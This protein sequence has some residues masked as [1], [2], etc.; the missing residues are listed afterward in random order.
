MRS[1][2]RAV[3]WA[4]ALLVGA[5]NP[6]LAQPSPRI[7]VMP[8]ENVA[9]DPQI[10]WLGE[11][12]S[13]LLADNLNALGARAI[14][15]EERQDAFNHLQ[16][17]ST[18]PLS[19]AMTLRIGQLVGASRVVLGTIRRTGDSLVVQAR[20]IALETGRA[21]RPEGEAAP[22]GDLFA[23]FDRLASRLVTAGA[24]AP[25]RTPPSLAAF[26]SY[27]KGLLAE[28]PAT[29]VTYFNAALRAQPSFDRARMAMWDIH[30]SQ[31]EHDRALAS[32]STILQASDLYR[33]ARFRVGLS[34]LQLRRH[35]EAF[36][37]FKLLSDAK[38]SAALANNMGVVQVRRG[39]TPQ[40]GQPTYFFTR[41]VETD[42]TDADYCFNLGYAYWFE[43]DHAAAVYWLR[44]TVRRIPADGQAHWVLAAALASSGSGTEATRERELARRLS[45][46]AEEWS[47][48]P[49]TDPVPRGWERV[50]A[51]P[52]LLRID[53]IDATI[54]SA[55]LRDQ[56]ELVRFYRDRGRRL[57]EQER[58]REATAELNRVLFLSPY[59]A[60]AHLL[61]GRMH[62]RAGRLSAAI[63]AFKIAVWSRP[64]EE[65]HLYLAEAYLEDGHPV[66][67]DAE[68]RRALALNPGSPAAANILQRIGPR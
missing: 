59:D 44:E 32:V 6:G 24:P 14:T 31:G 11:A 52:D 17:P 65:A 67:A 49:A 66:E 5:S 25:A 40:T 20:T 37:T 45:A 3:M 47:R 53:R 9:H 21:E 26:E 13:I 39:G 19:D 29:A 18:A 1:A 62:Q 38:G 54:T 30:D 57:F 4:L 41:A 51:E 36:Q 48:R 22:L 56:Q 43:R 64:T 46:D 7:L 28:T 27:V 15:R 60:E 23:L 8:F 16:I 68:A 33:R 50:K 61:V 2:L 63:D 35:D 34:Q 42:A 58:D 55:G 12:A 10:V